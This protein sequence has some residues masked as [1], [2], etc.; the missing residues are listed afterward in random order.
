MSLINAEGPADD[1][2]SQTDNQISIINLK[3]SQSRPLATA[4]I[5]VRENWLNILARRLLAFRKERVFSKF[6]NR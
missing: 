6:I 5:Q 3:F 1:D 4:T 2:L